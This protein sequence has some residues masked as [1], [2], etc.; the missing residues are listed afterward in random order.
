MAS[1]V[2]NSFY[3]GMAIGNIDCENDSFKMM[4][5]TSSYTASK[6]D[7]TRADITNEITGTAYTSGGKSV[8]FSITTDNTNNKV[9]FN[10]SDVDWA[11]ATFTTRGAVIYKSRGGA[12][13]AD[14][15]VCY[16]DFGANKSPSAETFTVTFGTPITI[17]N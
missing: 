1:L 7:E 9:E 6:G 12:S 8:F 16:I 4:L 10:F 5:V 17:Q 11:T 14:E 2:Y 3:Y 15:L 13:S